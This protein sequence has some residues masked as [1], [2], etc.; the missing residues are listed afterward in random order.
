[1]ILKPVFHFNRIVA[2]HSV[3]CFVHIISSSWVFTKQWNTVRFATVQLKWKTALNDL[4]SAI[5]KVLDKVSCH[6]LFKFFNLKLRK[7]ESSWLQNPPLGYRFSPLT[8]QFKQLELK[9]LVLIEYW[10][11]NFTWS[12]SSNA[13][14]VYFDFSCPVLYRTIPHV[15]LSPGSLCRKYQNECGAAWTVSWQ[16]IAHGHS[17]V[18]ASYADGKNFLLI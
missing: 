15:E 4:C 12:P 9:E 13:L 7:T 17:K 8:F 3:F 5:K 16:P 10:L 6:K 11:Q 14:I 1:M 18:I 2:K